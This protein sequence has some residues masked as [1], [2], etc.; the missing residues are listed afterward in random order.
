MLETVQL[1]PDLERGQGMGIRRAGR[2]LGSVRGSYLVALAVLAST[3]LL[4]FVIYRVILNN[5]AAAHQ[6]RFISYAEEVSNTIN[7]R[8]ARYEAVL[9][10]GSGLFVSDSGRITR[11]RWQQFNDAIE[12]DA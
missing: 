4:T 1:G 9:D 5:E 8:F 6:A 7:A 12:L 10:A 11:D 2:S 3:L